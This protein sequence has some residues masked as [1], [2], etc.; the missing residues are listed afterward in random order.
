MKKIGMVRDLL[1]V[2]LL[3]SAYSGSASNPGI[4]GPGILSALPVDVSRIQTEDDRVD[5]SLTDPVSFRPG[6]MVY[7]N[8][9]SGSASVQH[10]EYSG[11]DCPDPNIGFG[12]EFIVQNNTLPIVLSSRSFEI[13][14]LSS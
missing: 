11:M 10:V 6:S 14:T 7:T 3:C 4:V 5:L 12:H 1:A 8:A 13:L 2:L 9:S